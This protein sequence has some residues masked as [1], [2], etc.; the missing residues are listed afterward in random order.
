[1]RKLS[2]F[3]QISLDGYF[4]DADGNIAWAY[5]SPQDQEWN[6]FVAGNASGGG[7]LLFGRKTY[8]M[9]ASYWPTPMALE[10]HAA[11]AEG[12]N[13]MPKLVF[14]RTLTTTSWSNTTMLS[15]DLIAQVRQLKQQAGPDIAILGSGSITAQL[16]GAGL[17]DLYQL[18]INPVALGQGK[19][20]FNGL[21]GLLALRLIS[22]RTFT[23]GNVLLCYEPA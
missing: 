6:E 10:Q 23:N 20:L 15:G 4:S 7:V 13:R 22:S 9:M 16:A 5:K 1:M 3:N 14:S 8:E 12:M 2:V 21:P 11:V 17:I 19:S 18:V